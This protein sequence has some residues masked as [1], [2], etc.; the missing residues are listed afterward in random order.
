[1]IRT[2]RT[3]GRGRVVASLV[4]LTL[5]VAGCGDNPDDNTD[6]SSTSVV[7]IDD[8]TKPDPTGTTTP[9]PEFPTSVEYGG[10]AVEIAAEPNA[11]VSLSPTAT[12][13]L[14]AIGAGDQVEAADAFSNHPADAPTTDLDGNAPNVEAILSYEPDL[15]IVSFDPGDVV[16]GLAAANIPT[17]VLPS[18]VTLADTYD[19]ITVLGKATGHATEADTLNEAMQ[20]E[21]DELVASVPERAEPL[22]YYH[23]LDDT[24]YSVTSQTF[25]GEIYSLAGFENIADAAD[26]DGSAGGYPQLNQEFLVDADPDV[27]FLADT[28]C[29]NQNAETV[30]ARPGW[31][32]LSAVQAGNVIELDDDIASRWGPRVV[33]FLRV[34]I[35]ATDEIAAS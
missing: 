25:V 8:S 24:L 1:M 29:C 15:V 5:V 22:R 11:V 20:T 2:S 35:E 3:L 27:I 28:K 12:E 17:L 13:M 31:D 33:D 6:S 16:S 4:A 10:V 9:A 30:A 18:A 34:I 7:S 14:F 32:G 19:Q 23:E 26:A 21:I